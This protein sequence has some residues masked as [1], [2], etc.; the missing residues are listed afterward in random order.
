[1]NGARC[2]LLSDGLLSEEI[3]R[4]PIGGMGTGWAGS[5]G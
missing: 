5:E 1:M 3:D 4:V 2:S